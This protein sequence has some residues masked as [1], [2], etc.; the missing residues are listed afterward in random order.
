MFQLS[1][2][3]EKAIQAIND[4]HHA[5]ITAHTG[6]GK[7]LPAEYA[8]K[9]F[10]SQGKRV[11]Y[12]SPIKALSNQKLYDF[13]QKYPTISFG[14]LTGDIKTNP[15]A[16][17]LIMTTEI[18]LNKLYGGSTGIEMDIETELACVI[19]DEC[20]YINDKD[21]G[22]VWEQAIMMLPKHVQM[23]LLSATIDNPQGFANWI[24]NCGEKQVVLCSTTHR[25][26]PLTHYIYQ[27]ANEG[28]FKKVGDKAIAESLRKNMNKCVCIKSA[29]G[30]FMEDTYN[31]F[32]NIANKYDTACNRKYV[33]NNLVEHMKTENMLPAIVFVF[34]RALVEQCAASITVPLFDDSIDDML[35]YHKIETE[36]ERILHRLPNWREYKELPEYQQLVGLLVKGIGIHHSGMLPIFREIVELMISKKFIKLLF[37]TESFAIGLDCPIRT[38]VFISLEKHDGAAQPRYLYPHEYTQ[39]AGRAGRRGIDTVGNVIHCIN[40]FAF[41]PKHIYKT[42]L[43]GNPQI[44]NSKLQ[45]SYQIVLKSMQT[46]QSLYDLVSKSMMMDKFNK[47]RAAKQ[48]Q[49]N[50]LQAALENKHEQQQYITTP[51]DIV[52]KYI[53]AT[54][55]KVTNRILD[56]YPKVK[57]DATFIKQLECMEQTLNNL[58]ASLETMDNQINMEE[59]KIKSGLQTYIDRWPQFI[60]C[61][62]ALCGSEVNPV[63]LA[64]IMFETE[65]FKDFDAISLASLLSIFCEVRIKDDF[66]E[67]ED[68]FMK[69]Q[70]NLLNDLA[71]A[72]VRTEEHNKLVPSIKDTFLPAIVDDVVEWC[73]CENEGECR[74]TLQQLDIVKGI[75]VGDFVKA[76]LKIS[77]LARELANVADCIGQIDLKHRLSQIDALLLKHVATN[78]SLYL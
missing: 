17:V 24:E 65:F 12:T 3:Q 32:Y 38:A 74:A 10:V 53:A 33:L 58:Q 6:S 4:G 52:K 19:F 18:L 23:V 71:V 35:P 5:L 78:Q 20:H 46:G 14:L 41:P 57:T 7:T 29:D 15:A 70:L 44:L 49:I 77:V 47:E 36:C 64:A 61:C 60:D 25:V 45:L 55:P 73:L 30:V 68:E 39:M 66:V 50:E 28:F 31:T 62:S 40:L 76:L 42:V 59:T 72:L 51:I 37:A 43:S 16:N 54:Q 27:T 34:S 21:R 56:Q 13:T 48:F 9:H 11:I 8:I 67:C 75:S 63:L 69:T 1:E 22:Q 26:V 2:F